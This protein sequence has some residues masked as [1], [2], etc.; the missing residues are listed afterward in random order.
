MHHGIDLSDVSP[1]RRTWRFRFFAML[2][3]AWAV[4]GSV[5][6]ASERQAVRKTHST[7]DVETTEQT[8]GE[9]AEKLARAALTAAL[10]HDSRNLAQIYARARARESANEPGD[11]EPLSEAIAYLF[12]SSLQDRSE[13]LREAEQ[14]VRLTTDEDIRHTI[15]QALLDDEY[16]ELRQLERENRFNRVS[17]IFN[18]V[19]SSLSKLALLQPQ[20]AVQLLLDGAYAMR[21]ARNTTERERRILFLGKK[22]L[23][24]YPQA[25]ERSE[26]EARLSEL[27][28]KL[29]RERAEQEWL[30]GQAALQTQD[31]RAAIFHFENATLLDTSHTKARESLDQAR[32]LE[33]EKNEQLAT[34][35]AVSR[36][37][38]SLSQ[39]ECEHLEQAARALM[40][41][42]QETL[43]QLLRTPSPLGDS[44]R[45]A[46]CAL[47]ERSGDH[48]GAVAQLQELARNGNG[49]GSLA[50][51]ALLDTPS[52][53]LDAAYDR[54]VASLRE[55]RKRF[56]LSGKRS[57]EDTAY[58]LGSATVQNIG[59]Q[60]ANV[61]ALFFTD[62]LV[63]GV[64]EQFRTQVAIDGVVDAGAAYIRRFPGSPRSVEIAREISDLSSKAGDPERTRAYLELAG[65]EDP[66][67]LAKIRDEEARRLYASAAEAQDL[68]TRKRFLAQIVREYP[69][70]TIAATARR[71]LGKIAPLV[72]PGS[73]VLP[74]DML[75]RDRGFVEALNLPHEWID[76]NHRNGELAPEGIAFDAKGERFA[77]KLL[78]QD[79]FEIRK[80][81]AASRDKILARARALQQTAIGRAKGQAMSRRRILPL[82]IE[83]GAG[84]SGVELAPK[85]VPF[86]EPKQDSPSPD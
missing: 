50:A 28:A 30:A 49:P 56:I 53:H 48:D 43:G 9:S 38:D 74:R 35:V 84:A 75:T 10:S 52:Y 54:A 23:E 47:R 63:R 80:L 86:P 5:G 82:A 1:D 64:A 77:Y 51:A 40:R 67:K 13:F 22:F 46:Q 62:M 71:E 12:L 85:L 14:A 66:E 61:P 59:G 20:D 37:E 65:D 79:D 26:V 70:S 68:V 17:G 58:A 11:A 39:I 4:V 29:R 6:G 27:A 41:A 36:W 42:D 72:E 78:G 2:I 73:I 55:Q 44:I 7:P 25:P 31:L 32:Q 83:G 15:L 34:V 16:Y 60:L 24:R 69:E 18:R 8:A 21:K 45:F 57:T 81:G 3:A 33:R 19:S 76:G